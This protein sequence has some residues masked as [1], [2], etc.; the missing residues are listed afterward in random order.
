MIERLSAV[1][2]IAVRHA[3]AYTELILSDLDA[4]SAA[5]RRRAIAASVMACA[6][7]FAVA[8][9][10]VW[11]IAAA[12]DTAARNWA[13]GGLLGLFLV[14]AAAALWRFKALGAAAPGVLPQ[15]AREWSKD[16]QI[17]EE[18]FERER[19]RAS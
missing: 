15:T 2:A 6:S 14:I 8:M 18:L 12:W 10:C 5:V 16:R 9:A 11:L 7:V 17:L 1:A 4:A 19:A 3:G 13:I